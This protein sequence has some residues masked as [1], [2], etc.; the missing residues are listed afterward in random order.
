MVK[1]KLQISQASC[2]CTNQSTESLKPLYVSEGFIRSGVCLVE[3]QMWQCAVDSCRAERNRGAGA[4]IVAVI[5]LPVQ[6]SCSCSCPQIA[7]AEGM[8]SSGRDTAHARG[9]CC[10]CY[11]PS[12]QSTS[13]TLSNAWTTW[14]T[15]WRTPCRKSKADDGN[16]LTNLSI[17]LQN[18]YVFPQQLKP[19]SCPT[20]LFAVMINYLTYTGTYNI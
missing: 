13:S 14:I 3:R 16:I 8:Q 5:A 2:I 1:L 7:V 20:Y 18:Q 11:L 6:Q 17:S 12:L 10:C 19:K 15:W 9:R 4:L